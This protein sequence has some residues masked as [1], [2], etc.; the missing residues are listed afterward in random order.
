MSDH[1]RSAGY[2]T[3]LVL[4]TLHKK[5][6]RASVFGGNPCEHF[7]CTPCVVE[8]P[9]N[10]LVGSGAPHIIHCIDGFGALWIHLGYGEIPSTCQKKEQR[11]ARDNHVKSCH[12]A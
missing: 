9:P 3:H 6:T 10:F 4:P 5:V 1:N 7:K 2:T 12:H 11:T 8:L